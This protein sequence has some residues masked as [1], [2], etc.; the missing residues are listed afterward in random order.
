MSNELDRLF[1]PR[2]VAVI[3]ATETLNKPGCIVLRQLLAAGIETYPVNPTKDTVLGLTAYKSLAA[4]PE[5]PDVAVVA[6]PASAAVSAVKECARIEVPFVIV[7]AGGFAETDDAGKELESCLRQVVDKT[8][9]RLL[10]PNTLGI[11]NPATGFDT[12]FVEHAVD[13]LRMSD[14]SSGSGGVVFVSQSGSVGVEAL[15]AASIHGLPLRAFVGLG[16]AVDLRVYDFVEHVGSMPAVSAL[17]VY[18]EHLAEGRPLLESAQRVMQELP[19]FFLKAGRT[20]AGA[21]AAA[22]HTGRLAGSDAVVNGALSQYGIQRV[23]DD[24]EL[25][26][27]MRAACYAKI[28]ANNRV[29]IVTSAGGYGVMGADYIETKRGSQTLRLAKFTK[30]TEESLRSVILSFAS[31][32]NPVDLTAGADTKGFVDAVNIVLHDPEVDILIAYCFFAPVNIGDDLVDGIADCAKKSNK[33]VLVFAHFGARTDEYCKRFTELGLAAYP[34]LDRTIRAAR[35]LVERAALLK[36][37][38]EAYVGSLTDPIRS[39]AAVSTTGNKDIDGNGGADP[40]ADKLC[41]GGGPGEVETKRLLESYGVET[42]SRLVMPPGAMITLPEFPGP[43]AVKVSASGLLHK[44][45]VRAVRLR[46]TEAD[47]PGVALE[48]RNRFANFSVLVEQMIGEIDVELIV[49]A[50]RDPDMGP[51]LM[52]GAGGTLVEL[53]RD[54]SF[55]LVPA[56]RSELFAMVGELTVAPLFSGFRGIRVDC[57]DLVD[58]LVRVSQCVIDLGD[59]FLEL[60]INPLAFAHGK[61]IALDAKL[62]LRAAVRVE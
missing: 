51:A 23:Q 44:T 46:V 47:L 28:P 53:Y 54:T 33:T 58:V 15:G 25:I 2:R 10:G 56:S 24:E 11:Q 59:D 16:N 49:G 14:Q 18:L 57:E 19:V 8:E 30:T 48:L 39:T 36:R 9:T 32:H 17:A 5:T 42:P 31:P 50:I 43:Y 4:V 60:D 40:V 26:D 7:L 6:V 52:V 1:C 61:W 62:A 35:I 34:A 45:D 38:A 22:S 27:A 41:T 13:G 3:G 37:Q 12:V 21:A 55:R 20:A 29:A